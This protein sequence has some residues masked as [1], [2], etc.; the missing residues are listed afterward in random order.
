MRRKKPKTRYHHGDLRAALIEV[1][2]ELIERQGIRALTLREIG[3]QLGV[4]RAAPYK[5]F[6]DKADL[7]AAIR[8]AGMATFGS[9]LDAAIKNT[10][11]GFAAQLNAIAATYA[12]FAK[13]HPAQFEVMFAAATAEGG[14]P[15]LRVLEE[16]IR[17]GQRQGDVRQGD[18]YDLACVVWALIHRASMLRMDVDHP[19]RHFIRF[20]TEVL[21]SGLTPAS[22]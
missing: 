12:D 9:T 3:K 16:T 17:E 5:H 20:S 7:L 8:E 10:G 1:G 14:G 22:A 13:E 11:A 18:T 15:Y 6:E 21:K 2:L 19:E 4:S